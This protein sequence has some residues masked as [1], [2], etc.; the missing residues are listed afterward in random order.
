MKYNTTEINR[1]FKIKVSGISADGKKINTFVGVDG[2]VNIVEDIELVNK[3][4]DRA[5][6]SLQ[7]K[8]ECKLRRGIK[9]TFY[10][11]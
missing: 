9:V 11:H 4:L 6:K 5:F 2:L 8:C 3:M 7:D 1:N 10:V